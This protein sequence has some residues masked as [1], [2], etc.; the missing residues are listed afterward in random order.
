M[1][2]IALCADECGRKSCPRHPDQYKPHE[3]QDYMYLKGT[4][5]CPIKKIDETRNDVDSK[6]SCLA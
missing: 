3:W 2:D 1:V 4:E 6:H 5:F